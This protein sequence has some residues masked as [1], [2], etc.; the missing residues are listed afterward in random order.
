MADHAGGKRAYIV[1]AT[2]NLLAGK[3]MHK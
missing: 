1:K 3:L 2:W